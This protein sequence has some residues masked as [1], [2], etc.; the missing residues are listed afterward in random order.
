MPNSVHQPEAVH[1]GLKI[2]GDMQG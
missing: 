1:W 2:K